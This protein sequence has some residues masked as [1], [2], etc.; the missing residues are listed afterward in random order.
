MPVSA[1]RRSLQEGRWHFQH[2]PIDMVLQSDGDEQ[3]CA[4]ALE[5][6]WQR[7]TQV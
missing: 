1:Q 2:G 7:F 5:N 6:A 3:A 4:F